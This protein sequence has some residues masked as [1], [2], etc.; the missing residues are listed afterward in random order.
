MTVLTLRGIR[1]SGPMFWRGD[2]TNS[3]NFMD[4]RAN[5]STLAVVFPGLLGRDGFLSDAQ[6]DSLTDWAL[7]IVPPPN[8]VRWL[9][10]TLTVRQ[11][12][13]RDL[14]FGPVTDGVRSCAGCHATDPS[15]GFFGT[16]GETVDDGQL[17]NFKIPHLR[18]QYDKVGMFGRTDDVAGTARLGEQIR[19]SGS[20]HNGSNAGNV[21]FLTRSA[22]TVDPEQRE[23]LADFMHAFP[24]N[25]AP[26]VGQQ[27]TLRAD[28]GA[29]SRERLAPLIERARTPFPMPGSSRGTECELIAKGVIQG[30]QRGFVMLPNGRFQGDGGGAPIAV[31]VLTAHAAE[32]GG[33]LTFTCVYP[34]GGARLGIEPDGDGTPGFSES[35]AQ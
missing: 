7:S 9:D 31:S 19:G 22:F 33:E 5:F 10:N 25:L 15:R 8:P 23:Q 1:D 14:F 17:Q 24:T 12:A 18:N 20:R 3:E 34:G 30:R 35:G 32:P 11:Q 2:R 13:G 26:V 16:D 27:L 6:F 4:A 29:D 28:S 21:E